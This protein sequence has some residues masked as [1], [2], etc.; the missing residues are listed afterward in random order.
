MTFSSRLMGYF[1][2]TLA[3]IGVGST[4]VASKLIAHGLPPF[5]ATAMRFA[6][7]FPLFLLAMK[8]M[9]ETW[10]RVSAREALLLVLQSGSGSVGYTVL[11]LSGMRLTSAADAGVIAGSLPAV[12]ALVAIV[13]LRERPGALTLGAVALA[14][15]GVFVCTMHGG[16]A[17]GSAA[18]GA[19]SS[20]L[21]GNVFVLL[22][23]LCEALFILLGKRLRTPVSPLQMS[24]LMSGIGLALSL[25]P[26]LIER[27]WILHYERM[28]VAGVI[29]Y[30]L[31]PTVGGF[32]LWFAGAE[33]IAGAQ[34]GALTA[35]VPI[36]AAAFA[37][38]VL[39]EAIGPAQ[40]WAIACVLGAVLLIACDGVRLRGNGASSLKRSEYPRPRC[41]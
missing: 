29:Y 3:M 19:S 24:T 10:P 32:M 25:V 1:F 16:D 38:L 26:A 11:L 39:H 13:A 9:G 20:M 31:V 2:C 41:R 7:A 28:A 40:W 35:F 8:L 4:V 15:V 14:T 33:R 6:L 23:V 30:A 37:A 12:A 34:A 36:S 17:S 18:K 27:P 22:A 5:T 21:L